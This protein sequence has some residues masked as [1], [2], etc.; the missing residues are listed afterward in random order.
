V[1]QRPYQTVAHL[2]DMTTFNL[3]Q[4][5]LRGTVCMVCDRKFYIRAMLSATKDTIEAN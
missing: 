1:K 5:F 2:S 3:P 4:N